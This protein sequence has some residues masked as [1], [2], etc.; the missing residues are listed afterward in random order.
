MNKLPKNFE[1][2]RYGLHCRLVREDDAEFIVKLRTDPEK[3]RFVTTIS[4]SIDDQ[5]RW[6]REYKKRESEGTDYY[7]IYSYRGKLAGLN[8][9]YDIKGN[10]FIH[11][12][13]LFINEIPPYCAL[14]AAV[15]AR[16]IAYNEL[17]LD[18]EVDTIGIHVDNTIVLQ[19]AEVMECEFTGS[20]FLETGEYRTSHLTKEMFDA[21]KPKI[22]KLF[23]KKVLKI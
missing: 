21:N 16:E 12:S 8:R 7:F 5:I 18:E 19:F 22:L 23:P 4:P 15:V 2:D 1:L 17:G 11:G 10:H 9:I 13:W 6:I 20:H 14:A 3:M